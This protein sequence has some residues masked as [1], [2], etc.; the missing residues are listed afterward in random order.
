MSSSTLFVVATPIGNMNDITLR[1]LDVLK[2][3]DLIAAEDTRHT[4]A[5]LSR[6]GIDTQ[7][8]ALHEHNEEQ[9]AP[10]LV[11]K[12]LGGQ[13]IALVSDAGTPLLS[14]P[15]YRLVRLAAAAGIKVSPIPGPSAVT[16]ALSVSGL[17]TDRF[18]FEGFLPSRRSARIRQL[19]SLRNEQR[20]IVLFESSHRILASIEDMVTVMGCDR[21]AAI[22]REMTKQFETV[23]RGTLAQLH[24][25]LADDSNQ[26]KGEFVIILAAGG[27]EQLE[28][29][30]RALELGSALQECL[31]VS[32]AARVAARICGV[33]RRELYALME[34]D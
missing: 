24:Q 28:D 31:S 22:C 12:L 30:V 29:M 3:V 18:T 25:R 16:A 2:I 33:S 8:F 7:M 19:E 23:L 27:S 13:S 5:L 11:Q 34:Q 4:R 14:D 26:R 10:R 15:G 9:E 32:Q 21:P 17:A 20:S 6:H 1:A